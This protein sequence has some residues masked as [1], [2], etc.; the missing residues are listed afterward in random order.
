MTSSSQFCYCSRSKFWSPYLLFN[1]AEFGT[2]VNSELL[3]PNSSQK[4]QYKYVLKEKKAIL[5]KKLK[6]RPNAP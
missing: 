5:Y 4:V 6:F 2:V 1:G 3:I